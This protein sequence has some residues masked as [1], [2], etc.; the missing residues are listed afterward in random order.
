MLFYILTRSGIAWGEFKAYRLIQF[1]SYITNQTQFGSTYVSINHKIANIN[2]KPSSNQVIVTPI[3]N[4]TISKISPHILVSS[5]IVFLLPFKPIDTNLIEYY[6]I[7]SAHKSSIYFSN[8]IHKIPTN[9]TFLKASKMQTNSIKQ[10]TNLINI[11]GTINLS[12]N[13]D[14]CVILITASYDT[15]SAAPTLH[16]GANNGIVISS[17]LETIRIVSKYYL[18][19]NYAFIF[20][21]TNGKFCGMEGIQHFLD[22]NQFKIDFAISI[23]SIFSQTLHGHLGM[24]LESQN[25]EKKGRNNFKIIQKFL[26]NLKNTLDQVQIPL[27][28]KLSDTLFS[29]T[30]FNHYQIPSISISGGPLYSSLTDKFLNITRSD[31]FTWAFSEAL[32]RTVYNSHP[33]YEIVD[34][35]YVDTSFWAKSIGNIPRLAPFMDQSV[36]NIFKS[37]MNTFTDQVFVE[38]WESRN[39]FIPYSSTDCILNFYNP[40][41][42]NMQLLLIFLSILYALCVYVII[43]GCSSVHY[44]FRN[45]TT[46]LSRCFSFLIRK[47]K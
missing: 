20:A 19:R 24:K 31:N 8:E 7:N 17:F 15:F 27:E 39:C 32:F 46:S 33:I 38:E 3:E 5:P 23:E 42:I 30:I 44:L 6:L 47:S 12:E 36:P 41:P 35:P 11:I 10:N 43:A 16:V 21:M 13:I 34:K 14:Q 29:Q 22:N 18:P 4:A 37:W 40:I 9:Y 28:I 25:F 45:F 1:H 2:S 26:V